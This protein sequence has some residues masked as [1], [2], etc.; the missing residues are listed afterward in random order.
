MKFYL[1]VRILQDLCLILLLDGLAREERELIFGDEMADMLIQRIHFTMP[2]WLFSL[3][4][5]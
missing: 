3:P 2:K 5:Y 1:L 4:T